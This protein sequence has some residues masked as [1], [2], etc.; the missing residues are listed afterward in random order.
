MSVKQRPGFAVSVERT[1]QSTAKKSAFF[2]IRPATNYNFRFLPSYNEEG[3]LFFESAQHH[4]FKED[5]EKRSWACLRSFGAPGQDCPACLLVEAAI[6]VDETKYSKLISAHK[7]AQRWHAQVV[8]LPKG[9]GEVEAEQ[10]SII[11]LSKMT[12][13]DVSAILKMEKD[14]RQPLLTDPDQGQAINI[15]RNDKPGLQTRYKVQATGLRTSLDTVY[16]KWTEEFLDLPK[17]VALRIV[18]PERMIASIQETVGNNVFRT[19]L[20]DLA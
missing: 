14:N 16:P 13:A 10:V 9:E 2:D 1:V 3:D 5:G 12:A 17:A 20:P 15:S 4:N 11:G 18:E 6:T 8:V 7:L 19:L